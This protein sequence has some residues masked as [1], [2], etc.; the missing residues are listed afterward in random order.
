MNFALRRTL[1]ALPCLS[2]NGSYSVKVPMAGGLIELR[3]FGMVEKISEQFGRQ[4]GQAPDWPGCS[5]SEPTEE[6]T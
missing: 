4:L 2:L 6:E 3:S 5:Q 1:S